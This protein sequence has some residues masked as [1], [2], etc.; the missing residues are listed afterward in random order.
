MRVTTDPYA[1]CLFVRAIRADSEFAWLF[2]R[3]KQTGVKAEADVTG[4]YKV[5]EK[6]ISYVQLL[7][8]RD[9]I[10]IVAPGLYEDME[11]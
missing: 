7:A 10:L 6:Q 3:T 8:D 11:R 9:N 4:E 2:I 5:F 1:D